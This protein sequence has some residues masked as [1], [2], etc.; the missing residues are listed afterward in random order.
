MQFH[1]VQFWDIPGAESLQMVLVT[2][3]AMSTILT[4]LSTEAI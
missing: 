4:A 2:V 1:L 3:L